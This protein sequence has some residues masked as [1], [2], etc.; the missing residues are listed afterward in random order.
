M[1]TYSHA[2]FTWALAKH[3]V[4]AGRAAGIAGAVGASFPDLPSIAGTAYYIGPAYLR[5][6][7]SSM[8]TE[9]L[10]EA[11]YFSGPF[12]GTGSILHSAV[13]VV[14][15]LVVYRI[16]HLGR[17]RDRRKILLWFL[18]GWLGH[19]LADFLTHVDDV[20]QLFWPLSDWT[21]ASPVSYYNSAYYGQEFFLANHGLM[22]LTMVVLLVARLRGRRK[23]STGEAP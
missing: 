8:D 19:T 3:G 13:P 5:D 9:E 1:E 7:W 6:G 17:R 15:L 10:L 21:W 20:R 22:L 18:I 16:F 4:R 11:I 2:F 12:G 14:T 23:T